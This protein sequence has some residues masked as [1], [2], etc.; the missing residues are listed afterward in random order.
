MEDYMLNR[1]WVEREAPLARCPLNSCRR[2]GTCTHSTETDPCRRLHETRDALYIRLAGKLRRMAAE[3]ERRD[4]EGKNFA[5]EGTP[6]FERRLRFLYD[7]LRDSENED[8][9]RKLREAAAR[10]GKPASPTGDA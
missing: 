1:A 6:E 2:T 9:A 5:A 10:G 8:Y 3:A 4:P 7:D